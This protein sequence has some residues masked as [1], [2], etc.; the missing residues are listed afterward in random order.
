MSDISETETNIIAAGTVLEGKFN[1]DSLSRVHGTLI[2]QVTGQKGSELILCESAKI[3]GS[4]TADTVVVGGYVHGDITAGTKVV[5]TGSGR[6]VGNI[7]TPSLKVE[8]GA[9][10][11]GS[12]LMED[13]PQK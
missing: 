6:V 13:G 2:G 3:E 11:E 9:Y 10:F 8:Y 1:L 7:R 4:I 12:S 5:I